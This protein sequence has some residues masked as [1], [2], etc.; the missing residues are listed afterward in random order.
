MESS[1]GELTKVNTA[2]GQA[3]TIAKGLSFPEDVEV[4]WD[5][6]Q[7]FVSERT[8]EVRIVCPGE[9]GKVIAMRRRH[10]GALSCGNGRRDLCV[11]AS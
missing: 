5:N 6:N 10:S 2:N 4:A 9:P 7:A 8:G 1:I 11:G 3:E